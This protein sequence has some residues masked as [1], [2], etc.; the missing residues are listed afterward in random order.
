MLEIFVEFFFEN[1]IE[2]LLW[3]KFYSSFFSFFIILI[4]QSLE[5]KL[6]IRQL[7]DL[8][9]FFKWRYGE[10]IPEF[11]VKKVCLSHD[12]YYLFSPMIFQK[13]ITDLQQIFFSNKI[14]FF[15]LKNFFPGWN[16]ASSF[17]KW[18]FN[19]IFLNK[20]AL[21]YWYFSSENNEKY[22]SVE[23]SKKKLITKNFLL[24]SSWSL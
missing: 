17:Y 18:K 16:F 1:L 5:I 21:T 19:L 12:F 22:Q 6:G 2:K 8:G 4:A 7:Y 10:F 3:H 13:N 9:K 23:I 11:D 20:K 15:S 24:I 14:L